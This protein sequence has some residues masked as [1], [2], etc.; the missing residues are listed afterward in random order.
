LTI[1]TSASAHSS[2]EKATL[3]AGFGRSNVRMVRVDADFALDPKALEE[4]IL[5]DI[6]AGC[7]PCAIVAAVGGTATVSIDPI[8]RIA[9]I[10]KRHGLWLHVDAAMA[11]NAMILPELRWMWDGVED[12]DS[13]VINAHKWLLISVQRPCAGN[14]MK[15]ASDKLALQREPFSPLMLGSSRN[16]R[17]LVCR[18]AYAR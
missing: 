6:A 11:G 1:Y 17:P 18:S 12:A 5:A 9:G 16:R 8:A 13:L 2:V 3:L 4:A 14:F 7:T 10:A 15:Q